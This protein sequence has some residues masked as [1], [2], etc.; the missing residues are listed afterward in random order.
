MG[1]DG[2]LVAPTVENVTSTGCVNMG[3]RPPRPWNALEAD[4]GGG[5]R[6]RWAKSAQGID[7]TAS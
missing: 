7:Q 5:H 3:G 4:A 6:R 1:S 2:S